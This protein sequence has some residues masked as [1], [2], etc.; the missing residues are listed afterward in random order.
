MIIKSE[1]ASV[2]KVDTILVPVDGSEGSLLAIDTAKSY[3]TK[4]STLKIVL[5]HVVDVGTRGTMHE[6]YSY[7]PVVEEALIKRGEKLLDK[8]ALKFE[9][10]KVEKNISKRPSWRWHSD[11]CR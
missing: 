5:I 6:F 9:G 4:S 2:M 7:D 10:M 11:L 1:G 3:S 8:E